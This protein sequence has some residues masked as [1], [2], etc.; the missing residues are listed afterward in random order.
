MR[1][2]RSHHHRWDKKIKYLVEWV[3][4]GFKG[5]Q[6]GTNTSWVGLEFHQRFIE[7][8]GNIYENPE[9]LK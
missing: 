9:L 2:Q 5:K 8:I 7:V 4:T 1:Q 6:L 3:D